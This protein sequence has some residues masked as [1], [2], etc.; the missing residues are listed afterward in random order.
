MTARSIADWYPLIRK[1][2]ITP[3]NWVFAPV[4]TALYGMMGFA[5]WRVWRRGGIANAPAALLAFFVQ[6]ALN[7]AWSYIF[8]GRQ[9]IGLALV[10]IAALFVAIVVTA[11]LFARTDR[12]AAWLMAPY[13]TWVAYASV[14]NGW[15]WVLNRAA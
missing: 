2:P 10:E 5:A 3:P 12:L 13:A 9:Q 15:I 4:W 6:L 11:V 1:P 8:F 14:L 7:L